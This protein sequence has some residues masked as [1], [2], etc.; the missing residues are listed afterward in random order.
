MHGRISNLNS[1]AKMH[2]DRCSAGYQ[3]FNEAARKANVTAKELSALSDQSGI[4]LL[5]RFQQA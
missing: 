2:A 3:D 4:R 1:S 5:N